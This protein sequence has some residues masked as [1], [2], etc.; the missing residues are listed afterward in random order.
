MAQG[1][2]IATLPVRAPG[3]EARLRHDL[4]L[5]GTRR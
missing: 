5:K 3:R 2:V 4:N 1:S